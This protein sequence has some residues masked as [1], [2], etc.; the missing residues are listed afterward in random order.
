M[1]I[2]IHASSHRHNYLDLDPTDKDAYGPPLLRMT[3]DWNDNELRM[4]KFVDERYTEIGRALNGSGLGGSTVLGSF[5]GRNRRPARLVKTS[6]PV[7][8][9][10]HCSSLLSSRGQV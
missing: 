4:M 7:S 2:H 3:F 5:P 10:F 6:S 9:S 1:G 8:W